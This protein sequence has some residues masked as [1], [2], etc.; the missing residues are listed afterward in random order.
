MSIFKYAKYGP[1]QLAFAMLTAGIALNNLVMEVIGAALT[2]LMVAFVVV[3]VIQSKKEKKE[4][5]TGLIF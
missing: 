3:D 5:K 2:A 4:K 1:A